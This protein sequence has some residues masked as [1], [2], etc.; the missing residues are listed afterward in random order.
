M[1]EV[2][3]DG[4]EVNKRK[5][6]FTDEGSPPM[7]G[8]NSSASNRAKRRRSRKGL[9]KQY[10]C[11]EAECGKKF[12]RLE[13]LYRHQLN[14]KP[15]E[16]FHC[17]WP[18]C[19][20][21]FV[22]EDLKI[23]H[24]ER[25]E[26]RQAG[27]SPTNENSSSSGR[28]RSINNSNGGSHATTN[29][30]PPFAAAATTNLSYNGSGSEGSPPQ[31]AANLFLDG[32]VDGG[33]QLVKNDSNSNNPGGGYYNYNGTN[34][35]YNHS[36]TL[37][38]IQTATTVMETGMGVPSTISDGVNNSSNQY[39]I[40]GRPISDMRTTSDYNSHS[41]STTNTSNNKGTASTSSEVANPS[42]LISWLFSDTVLATDT[43]DPLQMS[44]SFYSFDSPMSLHSLLSPP[45][46]TQED[47]ATITEHKRRELMSYI[48]NV[49]GH[50]DA[51]LTDLQKYLAKYW[52]CIH[53]QYPILHKPTFD[54]HKCP[55]GLLWTM[56]LVGSA[57]DKSYDL[58][59]KI[60]E[61]LRWLIFGS[62]DF[63]PPTKLWIIQALVL[64]E[65]YEK[66]MSNR[67]A[68]ERA[69]IH[70][71]TTLQLLRRGSVLRGIESPKEL[72]PWNRW[73]ET[74]AAKRAALMAF[75]LDVFDATMFGHSMVMAV[76]EIRLSLPCPE[77][78]WAEFPGDKGIPRLQNT[79]FLVALKKLLNHTHVDT[80]PFGRRVLLAGLLCL[81]HQMQQRDLQICSVGLG[82]FK[83]TWRE[84]LGPAYNFWKYDYDNSLP[85]GHSDVPGEMVP[86]SNYSY[87]MELQG[88]TSS[89]YHLA[90]MTLFITFLDVQAYAGCPA[91]LN[92]TI[93]QVD[94]E[95][96]VRKVNEWAV[97]VYG[98]QA[99]WHAI[100]FLREMY[101]TEQNK[102]TQSLYFATCNC[103]NPSDDPE[104]EHEHE[105]EQQQQQQHHHEDKETNNKSNN[106]NNTNKQ[107]NNTNNTAKKRGKTKKQPKVPLKDMIRLDYNA[108]NDPVGKRPNAVY[109]CSLIV[110]AFGYCLEGPET[111]VL[112]DT[113][114]G[115]ERD[116]RNSGN[117]NDEQL[118]NGDLKP[119][120]LSPE[121]AIQ[122]IESDTN[123]IPSAE[124]G[125]EF[126][127]RM[128]QY[129]P[130]EISSA[131]GKNQTVGLIR[132]VNQSI[133]HHHAE[134]V[135]EGRR[136]LVH[137]I[138]RSL[139][140]NKVRC[141]YMYG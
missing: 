124:D 77:N 31:G 39:N 68:H 11:E 81:Q 118:T 114:S 89:F 19:E 100:Q 47:S 10:A 116:L 5:A 44:P 29:G 78:I 111:T 62:P 140:R 1:T 121:E 136:L 54:V 14:H 40:I 83:E 134:L 66:T 88:C 125:Y 96:S 59:S 106:N 132:M 41:N 49:E 35:Y 6:S 113:M 107:T 117:S 98:R 108:F 37:G 101:L 112:S 58:A 13:H 137:C 12:T 63:H 38:G 21:T 104:H 55:T 53:P 138:D 82:Q 76:H 24:V 61:P 120:R 79:P 95:N 94:H 86:H 105:N 9:E 25:H 97:S 115:I 52:A 56:I 103:P 141:E 18:G 123:H 48:P 3:E 7:N 109:L 75:V 17:T 122:I 64:L 73:I 119:D 91:T 33:P 26:R 99:Y 69:H 51:Q 65:L 42:D 36:S 128:S 129:E 102:E 43:K 110:W 46:V 71:A 74:E 8:G 57:I 15:K 2:M 23:R 16:I 32:V 131:T 135:Q 126:L 60:A 133:K 34:G 84:V 92:Q 72:D 80:G 20:K 127:H 22:R 130:N 28:K 70:H 85:G 30:S 87:A 4:V 90:H 139:G 67:K 27:K 93:R 50:H 45:E